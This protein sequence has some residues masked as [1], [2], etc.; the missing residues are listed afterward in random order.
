GQSTVISAVARS[1]ET[2][3]FLLTRSVGGLATSSPDS[4]LISSPTSAAAT[5]L[6]WASTNPTRARL[7]LRHP[8]RKAITLDSRPPPREQ[9]PS[10]T[11]SGQASA[12]RET[13]RRRAG[14]CARN[15]SPR[16]RG[17]NDHA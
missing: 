8:S 14:G 10:A 15:R 9:P 12:V 13:T 16:G 2:S 11:A 3:G 5:P 17:R 7:P 4:D 1:S 6:P